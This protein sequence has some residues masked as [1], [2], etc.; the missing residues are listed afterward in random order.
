MEFLENQEITSFSKMT[1]PHGIGKSEPS[2]GKRYEWDSSAL[3]YS[4]PPTKLSHKHVH[5]EAVNVSKMVALRIN[6]SSYN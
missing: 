5:T 4:P 3:Y 1:M 2:S 6:Y